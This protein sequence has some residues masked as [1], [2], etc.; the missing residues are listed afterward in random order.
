[1]RPAHYLQGT[2]HPW[3]AVLFVVPLLLLYEGGVLLVGRGAA[4]SLRNGADAWLRG[5]LDQLGIAGTLAPPVL[6]L[7]LLL[8]W[9]CTRWPDRP[10]TDFVS[11]CTGMLAESVAFAL[12]LCAAGQGFQPLLQ[13]LGLSLAQTSN[14]GGEGTP[15]SQWISYVGAGIYEEALFRLLLFS[16]LTAAF[17][18]LDLPLIGSA[19]LSAAVSALAF[20]AA[21]HLGDHGEAF[22]NHVFLFRTFA[23]LYFAVLF[24]FR[25]FGIAVGAHTAYDLLVAV[26]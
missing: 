21:H 23:G 9:T 22:N 19:L 10:E 6:L 26:M 11:L 17:R 7:A 20:A 14:A 13:D 1:M 8:L 5:G 4:D 2:R 15:L 18:L 16:V 24:Y 25:G 3:A 12:A